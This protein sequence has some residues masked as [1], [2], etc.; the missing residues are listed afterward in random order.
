MV[1]WLV[2][3]LTTCQRQAPAAIVLRLEPT[4]LENKLQRK[5]NIAGIIDRSKDLPRV[6]IRRSSYS[7]T[8]A[9]INDSSA[10]QRKIRMIQGIEQ[11][12]PELKRSALPQ[13]FQCGVFHDGKICIEKPGTPNLI[14]LRVP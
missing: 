9:A 3:S 12:C 6:T 8:R 13:E 5:L 7:R 2:M 14:S 4:A 10:W 11:L 1:T